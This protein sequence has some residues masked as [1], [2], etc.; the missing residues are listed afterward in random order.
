MTMSEVVI[1]EDIYP[2]DPE[3]HEHKYLVKQS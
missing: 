1:E 2:I 3:F